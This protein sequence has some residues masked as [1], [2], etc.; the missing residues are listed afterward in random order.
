MSAESRLAEL[1]IELPPAP[2]AM[3]V[4]KPLI[5]VGNLA[6]VS[7]H[8]PLKSDGSLITGSVGGELDL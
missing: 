6:Y 7:G 3:G 8:G 1:K 4:Y 5:M 2:K